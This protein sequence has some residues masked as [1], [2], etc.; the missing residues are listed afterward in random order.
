PVKVGL[1][2]NDPKAFQ[3]YTLIAP[4][5][6]TKTYLLDMQGRVVH[7]WQSD[8]SPASCGYLLEN[9]HLLRPGSVGSEAQLFGPGP[10]VG[11]RI[12]EFT[13]DGEV[14]WDFRFVNSRQLAHHD[15]TPLPNGNILM[16]VWDRKLAPESIAAGRRPELTGDSHLLPDSLIEIKPT[17]KTSGEVVWEWHLWDHLVQDYDKSRSNYGNVAEHPE[18]VNINFGEDALA[19]VA[20]T[21]DAQDKLK[22]IGYVG[23]TGPGGRPPRVN[24]DYTHCNG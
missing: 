14:V 24:P 6:S 18:L 15:I 4:L 7:S 3:G 17:G 23:A 10:G 8:C 2:I 11:G 12:Q 5:S 20:T 9:G 16:I 21:K 22:S 13:W 1:S 19:A